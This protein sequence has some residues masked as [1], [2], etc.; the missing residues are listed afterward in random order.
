MNVY[1]N[2]DGNCEEAFQ[3]YRS[4]GEFD[5]MQRFADAP[6]DAGMPE[7]AKSFKNFSFLSSCS[8]TTFLSQ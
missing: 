8:R 3:F 6:D 1:L 7:E 4:G 5:V 2:F